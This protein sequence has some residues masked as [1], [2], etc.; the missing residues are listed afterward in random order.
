MMKKKKLIIYISVAIIV[1]I[2]ITIFFAGRKYE[3]VDYGEV[4]HEAID[5]SIINL[6]ATPE[7]YHGEK[8]SVAGKLYRRG[9]TYAIT[10][11][12]VQGTESDVW[13][14]FSPEDI[15]M[16]ESD[17]TKMVGESVRIEGT[18]NSTYGSVEMFDGH[19]A[20]CIGKITRIYYTKVNP[21]I[22]FSQFYQ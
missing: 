22:Y 15:G 1:C 11:G 4:N 9:G 10:L 20:G 8:I 7:K 16:T 5:V 21:G 13:L 18:Y 19:F 14:D 2:L 6:V 17:M 12:A 3:F